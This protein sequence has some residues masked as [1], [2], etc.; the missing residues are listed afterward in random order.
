[1][2][3]AKAIK[4]AFKGLY[5]TDASVCRAPGR[6]NLI[7]EHTDYNYGFVMPAAVDLYTW[8]AFSPR[9]DRKISIRSENFSESIEFD[10][11]E[12]S[13][14]KRSHWSDY[15]RG[16]AVVLEQAGY[17]L[18]GVNLFVRGDVPL[19]SGLSSSA[20]IEVA[21][22]YALLLNSGSSIDRLQVA[23]LCQRA[24]NEFVGMQCGL[25]DQFISC[26]GQADRALMLDCRSLDY[27]LLPLPADIKLVICNTMVSHELATSEYNARRTECEEGVKLLAK[28]LPN[29]SSLRDV[30]T[31]DLARFGPSL[32][33]KI[34]KRCRHVVTENA[35]VVEA[36]SA[37]EFGNLALFGQLMHESHCS[38]RDDF[39]V[40]CPELDLMV[41]LANQVEG[42]C[43]ARM[44]GGGFGGCTINL[45]LKNRVAE[46]TDRVRR[47]YQ[48]TTGGAPDIYVCSPAQGA[49]LVL[50]AES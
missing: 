19:G 11:N 41:E 38:L 12:P 33:E 40:S 29:V 25:M 3:E 20:A 4:E 8:I 16:V 18:R 26:F 45:V 6:V 1:M 31:D 13:P 21:T 42:V 37:L 44:T 28:S 36:S 14:Q 27:T 2:I 17:T 47:G 39:E 43:G 34:L 10:L 30:T 23:K 22:A 50:S 5:G 15:P 48:E 7:G 35:R 32:P 24:E 49:E 9:D 46:M